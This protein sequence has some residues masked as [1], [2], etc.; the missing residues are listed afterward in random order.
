MYIGLMFVCPFILAFVN[1]EFFKG[2]T[3]HRTF[4]TFYV[5]LIYEYSN[6]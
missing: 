5:A 6:T 1:R 4:D 3:F 2:K